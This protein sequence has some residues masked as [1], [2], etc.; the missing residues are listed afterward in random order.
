VSRPILAV[1]KGRISTVRVT[2]GCIRLS[3][4]RLAELGFIADAVALVSAEPGAVTFTLCESGLKCYKKLVKHARNNGLQLIQ[5]RKCNTWLYMELT[6]VLART[7]G[8]TSAD[9]PDITAEHG[10]IKLR[11]PLS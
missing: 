3:T 8:F 2:P 9:A 10:L 1:G 4:S 7:A 11:K 5:V 6:G